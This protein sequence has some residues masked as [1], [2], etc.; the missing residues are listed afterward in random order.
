MVELGDKVKDKI[1]G[2]EG[3][4]ISVTK[5]LNGCVQYEVQPPVNKKGEYVSSLW[6]D[7]PQ[8]IVTKKADVDESPPAHG[9]IR[10]HP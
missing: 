6:I 2:F 1:C 8:L 3:I 10:S 7:E 9:G 4:A 5:Y